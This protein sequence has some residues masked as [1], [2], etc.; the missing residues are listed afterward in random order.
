[1]LI[2]QATVLN[3]KNGIAT[4]Q[5]QIKSSCGS[6]HSQE[7]CGT[8]SLSELTGS[9]KAIVLDLKVSESLKK[10][11]LIEIGLKENTLLISVFWLYVLP[12]ISFILSTFIFSKLI[13]N[14]LIVAI[15]VILT[16]LLTF[17]LIKWKLSKKPENIHQVI[18][19]RKRGEN[20][21]DH[22]SF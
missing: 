5:C 10:G 19:L 22:S 11:D 20:I 12:L 9:N 1:M 15:S 4:I 21:T 7:S 16:T 3:Y 18:F 14:E 17:K 13:E 2:E 6:C 8:S